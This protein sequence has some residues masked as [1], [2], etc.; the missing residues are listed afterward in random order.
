MIR[1]KNKIRIEKKKKL[2]NKYMVLNT[3]YL[4]TIRL[5]FLLMVTLLATFG[6]CSH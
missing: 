2:Q 4:M 1:I 5:F 6:I 3:S